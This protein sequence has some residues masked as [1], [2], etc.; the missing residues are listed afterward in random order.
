MSYRKSK[1]Y[2]CV[3]CNISF[4]SMIHFREHI[5]SNPSCKDQLQ[6]CCKTCS[7]IGYHKMGLDL[8]LLKKASCKSFY[9]QSIVTTGLLPNTSNHTVIQSSNKHISSYA[10]NNIS[11]NGIDENIQLDI[12][13]HTS[14]KRDQ[15]CASINS[16]HNIHMKE[17]L[18]NS[19]TMSSLQNNQFSSTFHLDV[20]EHI[21]DSNVIINNT[22]NSNH[23][24]ESPIHN[25]ITPRHDNELKNNNTRQSNSIDLQNNQI[26]DNEFRLYQDETDNSISSDDTSDNDSD[27]IS[28]QSITIH[29]N[30][31]INNIDNMHQ[32]NRTRNQG[33]SNIYDIRDNQKILSKRF[34]ELTF[35]PIDEMTLDLYH[36]LKASNVP[37]ILFD[38]IIDWVKRHHH[39]MSTFQIDNLIKRD[40]FIREMNHRLYHGN[41]MMK[42]TVSNLNLSSNR[43]TSVV[44]FSM[45]EMILKMITNTSLFH[46]DNL[47]LDPNNPCG[48]PLDSPY[49]D[50]VN[51]GTWFKDAKQKE[52]ILPNHILMPFCFFIDGLSVDKYGKLTVEAVL[53][54]CLWFNRK[55]RNRSSTWWVQGFIQDQKL[56][57]NQKTYIRDDKAQDYHDMMGR[58]FEEMRDI[59]DTGGI[60]MILDFGIG[61]THDV[62]AIPVIQYIIGDCKGNDLLCGRKGGHHLLMK[63]LCRDCDISPNLGDDVCLDQELKCS[64][65]NMNSVT[66]KSKLE[67]EQLSL[68]PIKNCFHKLPFGGCK[69]NIYGGTPAELLHQVLLGL[70]EYIADSFNLIFTN[71]PQDLFSLT[72]SGIVQNSKRQSERD[73]PNLSAFKNG[74]M[75][76]SS[77]KATERYGRVFCIYLAMSNSYL[78]DELCTKKR[79]KSQMNSNIPQISR[80]FLRGYY[81]VIEDTLIFYAWLKQERFLKSD[82]EIVENQIDS[83]AMNRIKHYLHAFKS[84][85]ERKGNGLKTPKFH[86][87]LHIVDY[88]QRHGCPLNYDGSRGENFGKLKIKDNAKLTNKQK[89][90]LNF[91][92]AKRISEEDIVDQMSTIYYQNYGHL[93]SSYC[94][95]SDL[96][97]NASRQQ[98]YP[99]N[100]NIGR[101]VHT[102]GRSSRPRYFLYT[103]FEE[104]DNENETRTIHLGVN[105][106][107]N[108]RTPMLNFPHD[109]L[110]KI[111]NR[112]FIGS[113]NFGG[114]I[115][116]N[117]HIPGYT[118]III[119]DIIYRAHPCYTNKGCWYDWAYFQWHGYDSPVAA[120]IM[121]ILDFTDINIMYNV[122][123]DPDAIE[124]N[125]EIDVT[126]RH[127]TNEKWM[128]VLAAETSQQDEELNLSDSHFDSKIGI[129]LKLHSDNDMWLIPV[130]ALVGPCF[131]VYNKKYIAEISKE[132][133]VDDRTAYI[134][135]PMSEWGSKFL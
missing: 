119:E 33:N 73:I 52:C 42:P 82:F 134:I 3:P 92:I 97:L 40:K 100:N 121:M 75:S 126:I 122:D 74:L 26:I 103:K 108:S 43:V 17:Y 132:T 22:I 4:K 31:D 54:C 93:P 106:G 11:T 131:V 95:E 59:Y 77:L 61:Q 34:S 133:V 123:C 60:K 83:R 47:L 6:F 25:Y 32:Q 94:N 18:K 124:D 62:I 24:K 125:I 116:T 72:T 104:T 78:I 84:K 111:A 81:N 110:K 120:R 49:Y 5:S 55:A 91:D 96:M 35:N 89:E 105:W 130:K 36:L 86:Q 101:S 107:G 46:P 68:L 16:T 102:N 63:G 99:S 127:L 80:N 27:N 65:L 135:R 70:C 66:N 23:T 29:N 15:I 44:T 37:L 129:R 117:T 13:D 19:R 58:I 20:N 118:E 8:H 98:T 112:L 45:K 38:R 71:I 113:P 50:E 76:V 85:I 64:F 114:K 90:N 87:M 48:D 79:K 10:I 39:N 2:K 12:E 51:S 57:R 30:S 115:D 53:T 21:N 7:Y 109:L 67:L 128:V 14:R 69:R 1:I 56:F 28:I 88:I 9:E 41:I